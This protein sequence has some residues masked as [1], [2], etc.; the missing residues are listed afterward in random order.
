MR[1][2]AHRGLM[3][4]P[5]S[6]TEND[7]AQIEKA[8]VEGFNVEIDVHYVNGEWFTG[9]DK[10]TFKVSFDWLKNKN[11]WLHCK[12]E[13]AFEE[14]TYVSPQLN[15]F[16]HQTDYYTLT[17]A[18]IPWIYPGKKLIK[19]GI[20]V[21]PEDFMDLKDIKKLKVY[22]ICSD[23]ILDIRDMLK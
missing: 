9:H 16:W 15:Y 19:T 17:S 3:T 1:M 22:G 6:E 20:C 21:L 5:N 10:P 14:L 8:L 4:G 23:Y 13:D 7:P 12:N 2:I 11:F 18:N